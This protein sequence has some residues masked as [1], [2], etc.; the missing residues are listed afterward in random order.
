VYSIVIVPAKRRAPLVGTVTDSVV[1]AGMVTPLNRMLEHAEIDAV[2]S[3][4]A[5]TVQVVP[6]T[7]EPPVKVLMMVPP[8]PAAAVV[9][10]V[11]LVVEVVALVVDVANVVEVVVLVWSVYQNTYITLILTLAVVVA[12]APVTKQVHCSE[13][14]KDL[15]EQAE[16]MAEGIAVVAVTSLAV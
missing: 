6:P 7:P 9:V 3:A 8:T 2:T 5:V 15:L 13:M 12:V 1:E 4:K 16:L 11:A 10:E 14:V